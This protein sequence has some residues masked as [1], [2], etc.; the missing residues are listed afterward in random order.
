MIRTFFVATAVVA[1]SCVAASPASAQFGQG[2]SPNNLFQQYTAGNAVMYPAPHYSPQLGG[3][4]MYTYQP[5]MPHEMMYQHQRNYYNY[6][7]AAGCMGGFDSLNKTTVKWQSGVNHM[8]PFP[9]STKLSSLS[10]RVNKRKYCLGGD[11][12]SECGQTRGGRLRGHVRGASAQGGC[13]DG[14]C[15]EC[16]SCAA[17]A[18]NSARR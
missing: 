17:A 6:Y 13:T 5:L 18:T 15:G 4:S 1:F 12:D 16:N 8:G 9:F 14:N 10:Y 11:C 7:N 3:Q 2:N